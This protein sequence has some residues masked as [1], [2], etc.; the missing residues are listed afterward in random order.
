MGYL[1]NIK[2]NFKLKHYTNYIVV[3]AALVICVILGA[4]GL[5]GRSDLGL[6]HRIAYSI[7]LAVSLNLVVG[8]KAK[9]PA[10]P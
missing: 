10:F 8:Y 4:A 2:D 3:T 6:L 9:R 5:L 1:K 7:V